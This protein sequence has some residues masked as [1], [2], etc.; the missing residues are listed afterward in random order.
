M[1]TN[2]E[3]KAEAQQLSMLGRQFRN[4][5][6][7]ATV[8]TQSVTAPR[9]LMHFP[10]DP[11]FPGLERRVDVAVDDGMLVFR[12]M[13]MEA[14]GF[15]SLQGKNSDEG[16]LILS[17]SDALDVLSAGYVLAEE[18]RLA[19]LLEPYVERSEESD[20]P[21]DEETTAE[22]A[23]IFATEHLSPADRMR[24]RAEIVEFLEGR[25]KPSALIGRVIERQCARE[26][27]REAMIE[28]HE[29]KLTIGE[30]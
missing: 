11:L 21:A 24:T 8:G 19:S 5:Q 3:I 2:Q 16:T 25:L 28:Q 4:E 12:L 7:L 1:K 14:N 20:E 13:E 30:P 6:S 10:A 29:L 23:T 9:A 17:S 22:V 18:E 15:G 27:F 26:A